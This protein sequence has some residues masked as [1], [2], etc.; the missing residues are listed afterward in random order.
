MRY[1]IEVYRSHDGVCGNVV[2]EDSECPHPFHGWLELL[3][4]LEPEQPE[5]VGLGDPAPEEAP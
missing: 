5:A 4:L 2:P 1:V 3:S